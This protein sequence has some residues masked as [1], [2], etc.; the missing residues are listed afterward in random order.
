MTDPPYPPD[1]P[2]LPD[3]PYLPDLRQLPDMATVVGEPAPDPWAAPV[4]G[5]LLDIDDTLVDTRGAMG[6]ALRVAAATAW[7]DAGVR[8]VTGLDQVAALLR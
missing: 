6:E 3:T 1:A 5:L 8:I 4:H 2:S 7:P